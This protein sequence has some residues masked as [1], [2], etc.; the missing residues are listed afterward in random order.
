M[1]RRWRLWEPTCGV[2]GAHALASIELL[3]VAA[4]NGK[5]LVQI[6]R[7]LDAARRPLCRRPNE[8]GARWVRYGELGSQRVHDGSSEDPTMLTAPQPLHPNSTQPR[9]NHV[10][11]S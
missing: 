6:R 8:T 2:D 11:L 10:V 1:I 4:Y 7:E 9:P 3:A 5:D